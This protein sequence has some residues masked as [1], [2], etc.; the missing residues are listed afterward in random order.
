M[1]LEFYRGFLHGRPGM[2]DCE[3]NW[4]IDSR[5]KTPMIDEIGI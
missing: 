5:W 4:T 1:E 3:R 2:I